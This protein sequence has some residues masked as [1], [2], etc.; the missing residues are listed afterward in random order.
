MLAI[1]VMV[2]GCSGVEEVSNGL[3][4]VSEASDFVAEVQ[5]FAEEIPALSEEAITDLTAQKKLKDL[6]TEMKAD[7]QEF[8][9]LTPPSMIEEIHNQL[10]ELNS[11]LENRID[12]YLT[13]IE[14]GNLSADI[15]SE[16]GLLEE[17]S[18]YTDLLEQIQ[19]LDQ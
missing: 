14:D 18:V 11:A 10:S 8:D 16:I 19:K 9:S 7:I 15:L 4:Y 6:L 1:T 12:N 5:T 17:I 13:A 3:N 2:T